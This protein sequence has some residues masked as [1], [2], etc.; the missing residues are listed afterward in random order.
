MKRVYLSKLS[1]C[2]C[3]LQG[4][5]KN[6]LYLTVHDSLVRLVSQNYAVKNMLKKT[7]K[8]EKVHMY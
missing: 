5:G 4:F 7:L 6:I 8:K 3:G 2:S 1:E